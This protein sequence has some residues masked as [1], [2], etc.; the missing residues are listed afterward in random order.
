MPVFLL[1]MFKRAK[2]KAAMQIRTLVLRSRANGVVVGLLLVYLFWGSLIYQCG[3]VE[4]NPGPASKQDGRR[5]TRLDSAGMTGRPSLERPATQST[6]AEPSLTDVMTTLQAM[7]EL[8]DT[9]F[10]EVKQEVHDLR[11]EYVVLQGE[12]KGLREEVGELRQ[13]NSDLQKKNQDLTTK[14]DYL[15]KRTDDLEGRSKRNNLI[16]YGMHRSQNETSADCEGLVKDLI[17]DK[18]EL[19]EDIEFDRV[20]R[21]SSKADSPVIARCVFYKQKLAILKAKRKLQ[22]SNIFVAENFSNRVRDVRRRLT[23]HLKKA[24]NES[25]KVTMVFDHLVIDGKKFMLGDGDA[26]VEIK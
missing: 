25:K 6:S 1:F 11:E 9:K 10:S 8:M 3:D 23:P 7:T 19:S 22:G 21:L 5:Q 13:E 16:F 14:L 20:H 12:L 15:E 2:E 26:L 24:R 18:L 17:T 4:R